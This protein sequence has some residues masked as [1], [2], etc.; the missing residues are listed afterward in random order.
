[1]PRRGD[2]LLY[3]VSPKVLGLLGGSLGN[4]ERELEL[5]MKV[6]E[7]MSQ[8]DLLLLE[9]RLASSTN[10]DI[11][12]SWDR[13]TEFPISTLH[14]LGLPFDPGRMTFRAEQGLSSIPKTT[15]CVVGYDAIELDGR[16]YADI[17]LSHVHL[18]EEEAFIEALTTVG[19]EIV[20]CRQGG[21][22]QD[23]LVCVA[24]VSS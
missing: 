10:P 5:L 23:F 16:R 8:K 1:M 17:S 2:V 21:S 22:N 4:L 3:R 18:Y 6:R 24:G 9:V 13:Q 14:A 15:T 20:H 19:F 11:E 12:L 7:M